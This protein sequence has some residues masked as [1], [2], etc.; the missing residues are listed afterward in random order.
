MRFVPL[1]ELT[2]KQF[3]C[4]FASFCVVLEK[5][6]CSFDGNEGR[7]ELCDSLGQEFSV[8]NAELSAEVL[9]DWGVQVEFGGEDE[10]VARVSGLHIDIRLSR[11]CCF[12]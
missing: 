6:L 1:G 2:F 8:G 4:D 12:W 9:G 7:L 3:E 5:S 11:D 10:A